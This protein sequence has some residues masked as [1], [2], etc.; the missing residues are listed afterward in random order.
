MKKNVLVIAAV[1]L[2]PLIIWSLIPSDDKIKVTDMGS[3]SEA[4]QEKVFFAVPSQP[5]PILAEPKQK[6]SAP[7]IA[8]LKIL[9]EIFAAKN[10]NDPR[11]DTEFNDMTPEMKAAL[12]VSY[13]SLPKERLN[14]RGTMIFLL[15]KK[16][17]NENDLDFFQDVIAEAPCL[18]L[19]DCSSDSAVEGPG[20]NHLAEA[21]E[22]TLI[23]PQLISL[24]LVSSNYASTDNTALKERIAEFFKLAQQSPSEYIA[25]EATRISSEAGIKVD[26]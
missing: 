14:E 22:T 7:T 25:E 21:Q 16:I 26:P 8:K 12:I 4:P 20:D 17:E 1:V 6:F 24:R 11:L 3:P 15:G 9:D 10:D 18:S 23:Y 13:K 5:L 19:Q 2:I